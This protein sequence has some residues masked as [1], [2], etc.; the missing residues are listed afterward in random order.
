MPELQ[1][2]SDTMMLN[3]ICLRE[4]HLVYTETTEIYFLKDLRKHSIFL[5]DVNRLPINRNR[6]YLPRF[7]TYLCMTPYFLFFNIPLKL[8]SQ[9]R[10]AVLS[11]EYDIFLAKRYFFHDKY[12]R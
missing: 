9:A 1:S 5:L 10:H 2:S 6:L 8:V 3:S 12:T 11:C 7:S 4:R